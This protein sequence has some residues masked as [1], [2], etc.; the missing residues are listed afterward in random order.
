[1]RLGFIKGGTH[2]YNPNYKLSKK[3]VKGKDVLFFSSNGRGEYELVLHP[4]TLEMKYTEVEP[5][6][7]VS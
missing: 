3:T 6:S 5:S 4:R 1:M 2:K 7:Q